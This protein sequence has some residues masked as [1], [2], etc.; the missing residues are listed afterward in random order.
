MKS[1]SVLSEAAIA[2]ASLTEGEEKVLRA[3]YDICFGEC[4]AEVS[5]VVSETGYDQNS[6]KGYLGSLV[7]KGYAISDEFDVNDRM[8]HG[9]CPI[10]EGKPV[11]FGWDHYNV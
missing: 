4:F 7:R 3:L 5:D 9:T 11:S 10:L 8:Y 2:V 6:V 1:Y